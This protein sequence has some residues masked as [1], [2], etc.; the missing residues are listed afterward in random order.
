MRPSRDQCGCH[1]PPGTPGGW[2]AAPAGNVRRRSRADAGL[3]VSSALRAL[4]W[5]VMTLSGFVLLPAPP[6]CG[7][8]VLPGSAWCPFPEPGLMPKE[9]AARAGLGRSGRQGQRTGRCVCGA[10][11]S[12]H[13]CPAPPAFQSLPRPGLSALSQPQRPAAILRPWSSLLGFF[14]LLSCG[15]GL[16]IQRGWQASPPLAWESGEA[17][18]ALGGPWGS[19]RRVWPRGGFGAG[20]AT[21]LLV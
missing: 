11:P 7:S 9:P 15:F 16:K 12:P 3:G 18:G 14:L 17:P 5:A 6:A 8:A 10:L 19:E 21:L 4:P 20:W 1:G 2:L 13:R